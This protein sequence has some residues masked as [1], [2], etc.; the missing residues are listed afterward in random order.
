VLA[1]N[2]S[3]DAGSLAAM[4]KDAFAN[5]ELVPGETVAVISGPTTPPGYVDAALAA[6]KIL[7]G[8]PFGI[9]LPGVDRPVD[10]VLGVGEIY[11]LNGLTDLS[12][13]VEALK[14]VD[15]AVD[16]TV[17]LHSAEH[18]EI[19]AAGTRM[20]WIT[21]PPEILQRMYPSPTLKARV[22]KS[23]ELLKA[24]KQM[25][26]TSD[27][28]TD[29]TMP[30]GEFGAGGG[31][32]W[33]NGPGS[34]AHWP[35]GLA[36]S[37]P[38]EGQANGRVV[39]NRGDIIFPFKTYVENPIVLQ[40]VDGFIISI[41]GEGNDADLYRDYLE[42]WNDPEGF[43]VSHIGWGLNERARWNALATLDRAATQ[44]MDGRCFAG[45]VL[46]S[47]G[48]NNEAGGK[49]FTLAHSDIP[50]RNCSVWLDGRQILDHGTFVVEELAITDH[51]RLPRGA[52]VRESATV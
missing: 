8:R 50:L 14:R 23:V 39:I 2:Q 28:G 20:L 43:A 44:G 27:A 26:I 29:V 19:L 12:P 11:G 6:A 9:A 51:Y 10:T 16:F 17:L 45:N 38:N 31:W 41:E 13:A 1:P 25:H 7:G 34:F 42:Q 36:S 40:I 24:A 5:C 52:A 37:Y 21:E 3:I 49:R 18:E 35:S 30:L 48:P 4:F 47:T 46:F 33:T 32:G 22:Q 15:F